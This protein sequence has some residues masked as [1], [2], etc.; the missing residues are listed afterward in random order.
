MPFPTGGLAFVMQYAQEPPGYRSR[1]GEQLSAADAMHRH[2]VDA[3]HP[4]SHKWLPPADP[5]DRQKFERRCVTCSW[6]AL[7]RR[8]VELKVSLPG[9]GDKYF[10]GNG[11][12]LEHLRDWDSHS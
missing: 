11:A 3:S 2:N 4:R 9:L 12:L 8:C 6:P 1:L 7:C 10:T 5:A